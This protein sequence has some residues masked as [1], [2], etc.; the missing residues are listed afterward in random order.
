MPCLPDLNPNHPLQNSVDIIHPLSSN[1]VT[2]ILIDPPLFLVSH[3]FY[4]FQSSCYLKI[5]GILSVKSPMNF[6]PGCVLK[7]TPRTRRVKMMP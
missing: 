6:A 2:P 3:L 4:S 7:S 1:F 5:E